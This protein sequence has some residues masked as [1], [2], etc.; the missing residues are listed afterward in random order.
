MSSTCRDSN[1]L[2]TVCNSG[3]KT[4]PCG[5]SD[6]IFLGVENLLSA[7]TL[8]FLLERKEA[9]SLMNIVEN[10]NSDNLYIVPECHV[11]S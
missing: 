2:Y 9:I 7:K 8:N 4:E 11:M 10:Y 5:A 3:A 1:V 6:T